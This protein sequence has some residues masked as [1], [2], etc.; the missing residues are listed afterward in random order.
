MCSSISDKKNINDNSNFMTI[1]LSSFYNS[2]SWIFLS[3]STTDYRFYTL[4]RCCNRLVI[5]QK[6]SGLGE[7]FPK[8]SL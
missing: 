8:S 3:L 5:K 1:E 4:K 7:S 6:S 2:K